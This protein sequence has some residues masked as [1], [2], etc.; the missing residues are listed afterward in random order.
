VISLRARIAVLLTLTAA[1]AVAFSLIHSFAQPQSYHSFADQR[2]L[3]GILNSGNVVSNL[4]F[5]LVGIWGIVFLSS[6]SAEV[7]FIDQRERLPY[8]VA[9]LG[10]F[11]TC[12]GSSY[13]H[14]HPNNARLVWD[15]LPMT[16][17]FMAIVAA[18]VAERIDLRAGL[19]ALPVLLFVGIVSV[20]QWYASELRSAGDLRMYAAVQ[21]YA[22]LVLLVSLLFRSP[23]THGSDFA[24]VV[25]FYALAKFL[26]TYDRQIFAIG[27]IV[28]GHTLKH[29]VAAAAGWWILRMLRKRE[30]IESA[31]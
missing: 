22:A 21:V 2:R 11:L 14:L 4:P 1:V 31:I 20:L 19:W 18:I 9:F 13:Y 25:G 10:L 28:S 30:P 3:F 26:E 12:F 5:A 7:H 17:V 8:V 23:Y 29:L 16:V 27:H 6:P 15:R 24:V